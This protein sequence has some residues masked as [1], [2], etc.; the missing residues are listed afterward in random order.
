MVRGE[1]FHRAPDVG[2]EILLISSRTIGN[3]C[4]K[5]VFKI[6]YI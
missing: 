4:A 5:L 6:C 2:A 3:R 1:Y